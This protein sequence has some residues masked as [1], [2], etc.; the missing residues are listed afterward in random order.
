MGIVATGGDGGLF[1]CCAFAF[2]GGKGCGSLSVGLRTGGAADI[3]RLVNKG[4][5]GSVLNPLTADVGEIC[6]A[7]SLPEMSS[8]SDGFGSSYLLC[9]LVGEVVSVGDV[10]NGSFD[11]FCR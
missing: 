7:S 9:L 3:V 1:C 10:G 4:D 11:V 6:C 8:Y 2:T 5:K